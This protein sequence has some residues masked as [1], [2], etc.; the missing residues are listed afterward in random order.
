MQRKK[1]SGEINGG[2]EEE[3]LRCV[4]LVCFVAG[5]AGGGGGDVDVSGD[6]QRPPRLPGLA[7][8]K[9]EG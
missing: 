9:V 1:V 3:W 8:G 6:S 7:T 4:G 2:G 5:A